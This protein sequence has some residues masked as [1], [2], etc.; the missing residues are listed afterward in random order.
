VSPTQRAESVE[1][2]I[3][4]YRALLADDFREFTLA[5]LALAKSNAKHAGT[6]NGPS[7]PDAA[8]LEALAHSR[9]AA[10]QALT[11]VRT[12]PRDAP[13]KKL[14]ERWLKSLI[15]G[16]DLQSQALSLIDPT[17]AAQ[18]AGLASTQ[19]AESHRLELRLDRV[20]P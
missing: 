8:A 6:F 5:L 18:A 7:Q 17:Q 15:A 14:A 13:G 1:T 3:G 4:P 9:H 10:H 2:A 11:R 16:L 19:I 12:V 20:L